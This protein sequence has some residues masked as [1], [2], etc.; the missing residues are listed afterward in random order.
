LELRELINKKNLLKKNV[1]STL[2][3][4]LQELSLEFRKSQKDYLQKLKGRQQRGKGFSIQ[5]DVTQDDTKFDVSFTPEQ[6]KILEESNVNVE[7]REKEVI[8]I[9]R[10]INE[11]ASI[12]KDL[13]I[14][15]IEQGTILD[16]IDFNL[17]QVEHNTEETVVELG[18]V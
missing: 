12:F 15:V 6:Q 1:Q 13:S 2:A 16:R 9:A 3:K 17:E 18:Q 4:Q 5:E 8:Q 14:L 11:L 10:S 7:Q